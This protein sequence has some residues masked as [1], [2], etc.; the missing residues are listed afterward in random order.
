MQSSLNRALYRAC[1]SV[2]HPEI[3]LARWRGRALEPLDAVCVECAGPAGPCAASPPLVRR[4]VFRRA[5]RAT[6]PYAR[7][8]IFTGRSDPLLHRE[9]REM[10][11][12]A[13]SYG[14]EAWVLTD[15]LL[16]D[17][18]AVCALVAAG[19]DRLTVLPA[20]AGMPAA[21]RVARNVENFGKVVKEL[22]A[23]C[24]A[25][26]LPPTGAQCLP[27]RR[28]HVTWDGAVYPSG[29]SGGAMSATPLG[30][31]GMLAPRAFLSPCRPALRGG[32]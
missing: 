3:A 15:G 17:E 7:A 13:R 19:T 27:T 4:E 28:I 2:R 23:T 29:A 20:A 18:G 22:G 12:T 6:F 10:I 5:A 21:S 8:I 1:L 30:K 31:V 26:E 25:L 32:S 14:K 9:L 11:L 16:L 24:P